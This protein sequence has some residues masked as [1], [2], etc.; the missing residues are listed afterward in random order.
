[1]HDKGCNVK[2]Y[3]MLM[4]E[5][6]LEFGFHSGEMGVSSVL[7]HFDVMLLHCCVDREHESWI[8]GRTEL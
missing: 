6:K 4:C 8:A 2:V 3:R 7:Q 5:E 1:M